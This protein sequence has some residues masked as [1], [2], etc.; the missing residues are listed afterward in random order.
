MADLN[1]DS[2]TCAEIIRKTLPEFQPRIAVILGSGLGNCLDAL[3]ARKNISY[4]E[5]PGFP[6]PA[7]QGHAG[8][9]VL[10]YLE[11]VP[12]ICLKG[13]GHYY[14]GAG[15]GVMTTAIRTL[16]LLGCE[17]LMITCAA[18]SMQMNVG[19]G[20]LT[21]IKDHISYLPGSPL[22]GPNDER[23]GPRF[24]SMDNAYDSGLRNLLKQAAHDC[25][26][27]YHEG[28]YAAYSGPNFETSAEINMMRVCGADL[29]GMSTVPE[30]LIA[31]HCGLKVSAVAMITN[32][33]QGLSDEMLS[34]E[35]TLEQAQLGASKMTDL[36]H[37]F[38]KRFSET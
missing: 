29:V 14:D 2:F 1:N 16:K 35:H 26:Q 27:P 11:G 23:F 19:P 7:V 3:D 10:G 4:A 31:R 8:E 37:A 17:S 30:V 6:R 28:V 21:V 34:H 5:L 32:F 22:T 20:N 18:G 9:L 24:Y 33:A 38:L 25:R 15:L 36:I 13:R 12:V